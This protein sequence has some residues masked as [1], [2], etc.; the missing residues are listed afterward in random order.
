MGARPGQQGEPSRKRQRNAERALVRR[1][2]HGQPGAAALRDRL[3]YAHTLGVHWDR[4]QAR[5]ACT[6]GVGSGVVYRIFDPYS[7]TWLK[8]RSYDQRQGALIACGDKNLLGRTGD[9]A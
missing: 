8:E 5:A 7:I 1:C 4:H 6:Q 2:D 9:A 3:L